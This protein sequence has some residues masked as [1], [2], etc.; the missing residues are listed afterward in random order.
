MTN[1]SQ[2]QIVKGVGPILAEKF[3]AIGIITVEDLLLYTPRKYVDYHNLSS[4]ANMQP[5]LVT[6]RVKFE[7]IS[8]KRLRR[9]LHLTQAQ[10]IDDSGRVN[11]VW[12]NQPYRAKSITSANYFLQGEFGLS[13]KR[14]QITNPSIELASDFTGVSTIIPVYSERAGLKSRQIQKAVNQIFAM[15]YEIEPCV[16]ANIAVSFNLMD[17]NKAIYEIHNPSNNKNL[18]AAKKG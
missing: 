8:S 14:M 9:G 15:G 13:N 7:R 10:A 5:G 16:P 18:D 4:I 3:A 17:L 2:L 1:P 6:L 12:F 11:V